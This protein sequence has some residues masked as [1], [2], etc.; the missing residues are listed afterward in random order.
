MVE[1]QECSV[2]KLSRGPM[3]AV[4]L[5]QDFPTHTLQPMAVALIPEV[6]STVSRCTVEPLLER[7][8]VQSYSG[9]VLFGEVF[10]ELMADIFDGDATACP[11]NWSVVVDQV[12][13][14][15]RS[16]PSIE[17]FLAD[18]ALFDSRSRRAWHF[19]H[20]DDAEGQSHL[21]LYSLCYR[22]QGDLLCGVL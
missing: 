7:Y 22:S 10:G 15:L 6:F 16:K 9:F 12:L 13:L 19:C 3:R 1:K 18:V 17:A 21:L 8:T 14:E 2:G 5:A 4:H 20:A 11:Y